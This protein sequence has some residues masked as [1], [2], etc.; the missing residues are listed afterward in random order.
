MVVDTDVGTDDAVALV[1]ALRDPRV[2]VVAVTA[3]A[4][5]TSLPNVVQNALYTVEIAG[6][7]VPV[8]PGSARPLLRELATAAEIHGG[9]GLGDIGLPLRG[10][11]PSAEPAVEALLR[12]AREHR[13]ELVLVT[14][15]PLT[16]VALACLADPDFASSVRRCVMMGGTG[17]GPGNVTPVAEFNIWV[18]P[19]AAAI[20]LGSG[21][22]ITMVGWDACL[23]DATFSEDDLE[24]LRVLGTPLAQFCVGIQQVS[25]QRA[26]IEGRVEGICI[27]DPLAM[28]VALEP[29]IITESQRLGVGVETRGDLTSGQTVVDHLGVTDLAPNCEVVFR[30]DRRRFMEMVRGALL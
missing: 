19:E 10:R 22:D 21:L 4:G 6:S 27:P 13:G 20:V 9:D 30:T 18:D 24:S 25:R 2:E 28:A 26:I 29:A 5:N 14:L 17:Q 16:N 11:T 8:H 23:A 12:A 1:L 7:Q 3:V 15:A